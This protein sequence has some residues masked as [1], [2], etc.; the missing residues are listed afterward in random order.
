V[1]E[2]ESSSQTRR[3]VGIKT[4]LAACVSR[5]GSL[6]R[7]PEHNLP[8]ILPSAIHV[9]LLLQSFVSIN[10]IISRWGHIHRRKFRSASGA[11]PNGVFGVGAALGFGLLG[12]VKLW[13]NS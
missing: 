3:N 7:L 6:P 5:G 9:V 8:V 10:E 12:R 11:G 1:Q 13:F 2:G 4:Y